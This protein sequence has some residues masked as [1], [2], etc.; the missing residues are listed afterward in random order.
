MAQPPLLCEEGEEGNT[1]VGGIG[2]SLAQCLFAY[3]KAQAKF[4][5]IRIA[6]EDCIE[7]LTAEAA[8]HFPLVIGIQNAF[9]P[10]TG[11]FG[12]FLA[13]QVE[14]GRF[15]DEIKLIFVADERVSHQKSE[16]PAYAGHTPL[17]Y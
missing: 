2:H 7:L 4:S 6:V 15:C 9:E 1:L 10:V 5:F 16:A 14:E 8:N 13:V 12:T 17:L 11:N 3:E